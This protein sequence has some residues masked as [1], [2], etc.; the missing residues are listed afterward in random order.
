MTQR[1]AA[2]ATA[3]RLNHAAGL[4]ATA[5]LTDSAIE[6]YRGSFENKAMFT[7][8]VTAL[9]TLAVSG[10]GAADGRHRKHRVRHGIYATAALTGVAGTAFHIYNITKRPGGLCWH[11]LFYGA[12]AGAP[13]AMMLAGLLGFTAE[14]VRDNSPGRTPTVFERPASRIVAAVS[15]IGLIGTA[16]EAG[17]LHFRGAYHNPAML[18]PVTVPPVA[19]ALLG[20]AALSDKRRS[21]WVTRLWLRLTAMLGVAGVGFHIYGVSRAMG[22]WRNWSQNWLDGPPLPAPP[23]FTALALAGL[24][25]LHLRREH[26]DG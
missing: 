6:H 12:P 2:V 9:L 4:L 26:P 10:H 7:P 18:L 3:Q 8:I 17:L 1:H 20:E 16:A 24:A 25:A 11:N 15:S 13:I 23:S 19:A 14:R 22:G 21:R 5:V